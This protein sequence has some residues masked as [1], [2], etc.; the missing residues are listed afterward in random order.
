[1]EDFTSLDIIKDGLAAIDREQLA[2]E[3]KVAVEAFEKACR[4]REKGKTGD[5]PFWEEDWG[6]T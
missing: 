5:D 4:K 1:L 2:D 6:Q 3:E